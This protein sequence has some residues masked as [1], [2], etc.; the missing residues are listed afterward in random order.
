MSAYKVFSDIQFRDRQCLLTALAAL[1][2]EATKIE[3]GNK[4]TLVDYVRKPR[5]ETAEIVIRRAHLG[6]A[7]N[8]IGFAKTENG[9]VPIVSDYDQ[10]HVLGGRFLKEV[11]REYGVAAANALAKK[12]GRTVERRVDG[13]GNI[14]LTL[15]PTAVSRLQQVRSY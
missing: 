4:V 5:P 10:G 12:L 13:K 14:I 15:K 2:W 6:H 7:S 1:G 11:K 3:E 8:D 9:Y